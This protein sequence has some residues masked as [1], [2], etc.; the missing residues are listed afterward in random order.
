MDRRNFLHSAGA[1][2]LTSFNSQLFALPAME[3]KLLVVF[4]RGGYDAA[5]LLI[6]THSSFY[7]QMRPNIAVAPPQASDKDSAIYLTSDWGLHPALRDTLYPLYERKQLAFIPFAGTHDISRSHFET[8]DTIELGVSN[9]ARTRT[10]FLNRLASQLTSLTPIAFTDRIPLIM[11][12]GVH[13]P[14]MRLRGGGKA[15]LD[16]RQNQLLN[17]MYQNTELSSAVK[18]GIQLRQQALQEMNTEQLAAEMQAANRNA[19]SAKGFEQEAQR[20]AHFMYADYSLGFVDVGGWDTHV[21]EGGANGTLANRLSELGRGLSAYANAMGD[22]WKNTVVVVISEF[23]RTLRE[24]GNRGTDHGH[25]TVY[26]LLGGAIQGGRILGQQREVTQTN[27]FQDRDYP[28]LNEYRSVLLGLFQEFYSLN[29][30]QQQAIF[31]NVQAQ[32]LSILG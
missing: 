13:I 19:V 18:Q 7:Y 28:V 25:G 4:L 8:Q 17:S 27:L 2:T 20:I 9:S 26:W 22:K 14:N 11:K 10:G 1:L 5:N 24:N 6:P 21:G 31:P 23:G 15:K 3:R 32:K 16:E 30:T 12:G 29:S